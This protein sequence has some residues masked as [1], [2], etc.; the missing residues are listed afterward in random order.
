MASH[1]LD[2]LSAEEL[3]TL[4]TAARLAWHLDGRHFFAMVQLE[5]PAK[6]LMLLWPTSVIIDRAARITIWVYI[7][8]Y[9]Y[10]CVCVCVCD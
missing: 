6:N 8:I 2:P 1:P 7:Y 4:V 3:R 5:E 10:V 9:I